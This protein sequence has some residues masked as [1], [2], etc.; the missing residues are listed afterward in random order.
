MLAL[1]R[2]P[3]LRLL[4]RLWWLPALAILIVALGFGGEQG[5]RRVGLGFAAYL[6]AIAGMVGVAWAHGACAALDEHARHRCA[7]HR[8]LTEVRRCRT[9]RRSIYC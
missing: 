8:F 4:G 2:N 6:A 5:L 7:R 1:F 9:M 3:L